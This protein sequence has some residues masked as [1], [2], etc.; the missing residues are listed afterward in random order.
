[1][2]RL[3]LLLAFLAT[4]FAIAHDNAEK[5]VHAKYFKN[6]VGGWTVITDKTKWCGAMQAFDGY[7]FS[8]AGDKT[9]FCWVPRGDMVLVRFE[10]ERDTGMWPM[11]AFEDLP[12]EQE[13]DVNTLFPE[14][15]KEL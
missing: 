12:P 15:A 9:R 3:L 14:N 4:P 5:H 8:A 6:N 10:G 1:M 11:Q 2:R 13:P 7:A